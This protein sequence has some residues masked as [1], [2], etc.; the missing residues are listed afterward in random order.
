MADQIRAL[1]FFCGIGGMHCALSSVLPQAVVLDAF[2][3]SPI[4]NDVYQHNFG[5][6]VNKVGA[7][8]GVNRCTCC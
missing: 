3:V 2:D 1:E 6:R 8:K 4:A 5:R 7:S